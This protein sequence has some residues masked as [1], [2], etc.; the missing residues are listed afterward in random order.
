MKFQTTKEREVVMTESSTQLLVNDDFKGLQG[1]NLEN[2][3]TRLITNV[4]KKANLRI[5]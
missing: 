4:F 1:L 5:C 2:L 3:V